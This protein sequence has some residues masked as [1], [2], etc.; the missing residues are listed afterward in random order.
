MDDWGRRGC[1]AW[2]L[3]VL[4]AGAGAGCGGVAEVD[5]TLGTVEP[6]RGEVA[7]DEAASPPVARIAGGQVL[8]LAD[9]SLARLTLDAGPVLLVD[10]GSE[11][12][13]G[14]G[15][16]LE[17]RAGRV[18]V[19]VA[20]GERLAVGVAGGRLRLAD[21]SVS[22]R[23]PAAGGAPEVHAIHGEVG[24]SRGDDERRVVRAGETL[25]LGDRPEVTPT[26][27]WRDWTGGLARPG[28]SDA[29]AP[30]G[31]G[32]LEARVPDEVGRARWSLVV[33]RLEVRVRLEGDLAVTEVDQQFFNPASETVEGLYR[34]RVPEGAVLQRFAVDRGDRLVDGYVRERAQA[35]QAYQ[36][37]VY[38]GSTEDPAL[39][40]WDAPGA[41]RARIY[42]I[43]PGATR[44]IVIR[45]AEWLAPPSAGAP[46]LY[47]YPM[48]GAGRVPQVQE[49]ALV[50][51]VSGS[52]AERVRAGLGATV[53]AGRVELRRS[54]FRPHADFWLELVGGEGEVQRAWTAPHEPPPRAP[55]APA[56]LEEADES[57]FLYLPLRLP[58][59]EDDAQGPIDAVVVVDVS[60]ATERG[61]LELGRSVVESLAAHLRPE[62]RLAVVRSDLAIRS[63]LDGEGGEPALAAATPERLEALL[64]GVSRIPPGG[65]TDLGQALTEGAA[66][67][68]PER[69][70]FLLYVG[71][72]APTVGELRAEGLLE[73]LARLPEPFRLY[74]VAAGADAD[75]DLLATLTRGG[76]LALRV[77]ERAQAADAALR[78]LA[79][80][81]RPV[82]HGLEVDLGDGVDSVYPRGPRDGVLGAVFPVVGR[83]RE[84][85]PGEV[86]VTGTYRGEPY[87]RT[88][89]LEVRP[90][91]ESS[92]LRLRWAGERLRQLLL[93]GAGREEVAELGTR[94]GLITPFTSFYVP[95]HTEVAALGVEG[96]RLI[97]RPP[98][99]VSGHGGW[100]SAAGQAA[101]AVALGPL[102]LAGCAFT[103]SG[104]AA[105]AEAPMME[106]EPSTTSAQEPEQ[107]AVE[108]EEATEALASEGEAGRMGRPQDEAGADRAFQPRSPATDAPAPPP[109]PGGGTGN[110]YGIR[111]PEA[112]GG[113]SGQAGGARPAPARSARR[114]PETPSDALA[115][116][117]ARDGVGG[118][119]EAPLAEAERRGQAPAGVAPGEADG[120]RA[121]RE[122]TGVEDGV[123]ADELSD[124]D[125]AS[126]AALGLQGT[127]VGGG[128]SGEGTIGLGNL[129]TIGHGGGGLTGSGYGRGAGG[130]GARR[131][132]Q[133]RTGRADVRGG[134]SPEI[135]RRVIRRHLNEVRFCYERQLPSRP[136]L[137][138]RVVVRFAI[139]AEG[140]VTSAAV[141]SSTLGSPP[142]EACVV[143][144]VRRWAFPAPPVGGTVAVSYPFVLQAGEGP[145]ATSPAPV[146]EPTAH[147]R[148]RRCSDAATK[149]L[150]DRRALWRERLRQAG[151]ASAWV[152]VYRDAGRACEAPTWRDRRA[153]LGLM[154][155]RAG[156]I[157]GML[158]L[159]R[160]L[161]PGSARGYVRRRI[162]SRVRT[163]ED[164]MAVRRGLGLG[165]SVDWALVEQV[166]ARA[167]GE[168]ARI[169]ALRELVRDYPESFELA[170]RLLRALERADRLPEAERLADRLRVAPFADTTVRTAIGEMYLRWDRPD[171]A[172]R[173]FSE[174]VE[175]APL[176]ELARRR[177]GDL[178]R[179]HGWYPEAYRQYETLREIRPDDPSVRLLLAQAAAGSGRVDEALRLE[180]GLM[181][182]AAPGAGGGLA[183]VAALWSSVRFA[184]LRQAAREEGDDERLERL[185]RRMRRTGVLQEAGA[186]R[187][188]LVWTHPDARLSLWAGHP[189]LGLN[190]P[191]DLYGELGLE[192]FD[193]AEQ[194]GGTYRIEVRREPG[195]G[196][197]RSAGAQLIVV[198][199]E[200][201][202]DERVTVVD[203]PFDGPRPAYAWT[204]TG[205][206][207]AEARPEADR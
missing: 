103:E 7:I 142:V 11:V 77:E 176:D 105:S 94:Y 139:G 55:G 154:L 49:L 54:D 110:R 13:L 68:D 197:R 99:D 56:P 65:A 46:R 43:A 71:D 48:G 170:L 202:D 140:K 40:E 159:Y 47:R 150:D 29:G 90:T 17:L 194:D 165:A 87:E 108:E 115:G 31:V 80:A 109:P 75:L 147:H 72:G 85:L 112:S 37:R 67:L 153:L 195:D 89:P 119:G 59:P 186:L 33:R 136:D 64:D 93:G 82:V 185:A 164:L 121:R 52:G 10:G 151:S 83:V 145:G 81:G 2:G 92:D 23:V 131:V 138:G 149:P 204:L 156:S 152:R 8:R 38:R 187:V 21:A 22:V 148:A 180:E 91:A 134:L 84:G 30:A 79:H 178:Y 5:A 128:G 60:A 100:G 199:R 70:G 76:G 86:R 125:D 166:L 4:A 126:G 34:I 177:L 53:D 27:L 124:A 160:A 120:L 44:R 143:S 35:R 190:R 193:L 183:R 144:A 198:W 1:F 196:P 69:P 167:D 158:A 157:D 155:A 107:A 129:G 169:R 41:Y 97:D 50:A 130:R 172:R 111:G 6:V 101:V 206:V 132:P 73:R 189:G 24:W 28:P 32:L 39:L 117:E 78:V 191:P 45:Y 146:S 102:S 114:V 25:T 58:I 88:V 122:A 63:V 26:R 18:F 106:P 116:L 96:L 14:D 113:S 182:T 201:E 104:E 171:E 200:G 19:E 173:A 184:R 42:P 57:D 20:A 133:V 36:E 141:G 66:L 137:E 168:A 174:I 175:F 135:I 127:G 15:Q 181:R 203:L 163:P 95:S 12:E 192:A 74:A 161:T 162:L 205:D 123:G 188:T 9:G 61:H 3:A 62:D 98:L 51:D 179:A 16:E 118:D 207:L